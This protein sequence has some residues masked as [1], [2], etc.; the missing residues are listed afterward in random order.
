MKQRFKTKI[1]IGNNVL[2][3]TYTVICPYIN[4]PYY[5]N[6]KYVT[7]HPKNIKEH[8]YYHDICYEIVKKQNIIKSFDL[9]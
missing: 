4:C 3:H 2:N 6:I 5:M 7:I 9:I 1:P 8:E